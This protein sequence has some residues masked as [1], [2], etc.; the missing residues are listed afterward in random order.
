MMDI[1]VAGSVA[2]KARFAMYFAPGRGLLDAT[3]AA[4]HDHERNPSVISISWGGNEEDLTSADRRA[5][6]EVFAEAAALGITVIS[7]TGDHGSV[8]DGD[9]SDWAHRHHIDHPS[10]D[11]YVLACG[12]T[13]IEADDSEIVWN[14]GTPFGPKR[15]E[16]GWAS[17]G[18]ISDTFKLP[19]Y[20]R[21]MGIPK[22]MFTGK[23][24]RGIPDLAM[25]ADNYFLRWQ[26]VERAYG[27]TSC[28]APLMA[29]LVA[30]L[31]QAKG[32]RVGFLN[33]FLY[34]F[35]EKGIFKDITEGD[36]GIKN[37]IKGYR[38]RPGWDACTGWGT[39]VGVAI[40]RNL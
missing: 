15:N 21:G 32:K 4:V 26:G 29:A 36:N 38:A 16:Q 33:P 9:R 22:S 34:T 37:T 3:M 24:G 39:P 30:R 10:V 17:G 1:E 14:D 25:T 18:G 23:R 13:Q 19:Y 20:Q 27:G 8:G 12:G 7:P 6:R 5:Y 40:L 28:V 35:A 31:N 11:P 2:P